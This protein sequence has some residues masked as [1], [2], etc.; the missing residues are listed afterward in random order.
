MAIFNI[1][2]IFTPF[3][4]L[5]GSEQSSLSASK[6]FQPQGGLNKKKHEKKQEILAFKLLLQESDWKIWVAE[7][8]SEALNI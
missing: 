7:R 3:M 5:H 8:F 4:K 2:H 1:Y 6:T